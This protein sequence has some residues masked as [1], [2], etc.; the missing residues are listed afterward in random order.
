MR[1]IIDY[2]KIKESD[3]I[4]DYIA[5]RHKKGL[6]TLIL[7]TG[8]P[9]S[10][11]SSTGIRLGEL[12][13]LKIHGEDRMKEESIV[14]STLGI[15]KV[16]KNVK[17]PGEITC[18]EELSVLFPSRRAM[19]SENLVIG[20]I[21]DTCRKRQV[22]LFANAPIFTSIDSHIRNMGHILIETQKALKKEQVVISKAWKLQTNPHTGKIYR[23]RFTRGNRDVG[24]FIT[25]QPNSEL[26]N[27][28][29]EQKD[30]FIDELYD[31]LEKQTAKK[32][33]KLN[34]ELGIAQKRVIKKAL[35][36]KEIKVYGLVMGKKLTYK[37]AG[38]EMGV[39]SQR[40]GAMIKNI[41]KKTQITRKRD[42]I[43]ID[44]T[45]GAQQLNFHNTHTEE[46]QKKIKNT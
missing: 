44:T 22:I 33:A 40:I 37:Q 19:A 4:I 26:W 18:I 34:K 14:D 16:L 15:L 3:C 31:R 27:Q 32:E 42:N 45:Q 25:R 41:E 8:L 10:G 29:E 11:K 2:S 38:K 7:I 43:H 13:S 24:L 6:Y 39:S 1:K 35:T 21:L 46:A 9:G 20:R 12:T 5:K 23:H 36:D 28:Y 17:K 30:K